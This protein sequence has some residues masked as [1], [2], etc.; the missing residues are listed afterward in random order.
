MSKEANPYLSA[1]PSS[2]SIFARIL[3]EKPA[4]LSLICY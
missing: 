2:D 4:T 1:L 3:F